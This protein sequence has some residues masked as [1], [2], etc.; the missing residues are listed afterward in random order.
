MSQE[1]ARHPFGDDTQPTITI[2]PPDQRQPAVWRQA[3]GWLSLAAALVLTVATVILVLLPPNTPDNTPV[4]MTTGDS[5]STPTQASRLSIAID[6]PATESPTPETAD[7]NVLPSATPQPRQMGR[8]VPTVSSM[9]LVGLLQTP[10]A[11]AAASDQ[12][13][14]FRQI[15]QQAQYNPFTVLPEMERSEF[16]EYTVQQG[17]TVDEIARRYGLAIDTLAWCNDS[18]IVFALFP[19]DVLRIPPQ[20]GACHLVLGTRGLTIRDIAAEY[21]VE[22]PNVIIESAFN[23]LY[24]FSPDDAPPGGLYLFIPGGIGPVVTWNPGYEAETDASGNTVFVTF[25]SG[26][27]GSCGRVEAG[28]GELWSN[29]LPNGRWVRG[30]FPGHTGID[31]SAPTGTPI[32]AAN[33]GPVLFSGTSAYG[34]GEAVVLGH[35]AWSTL[36]AHMS[37]RLA[38]CGQ[39]ISVGS[40]VGYVGSTGRSSGPHLHFE[41]RYND[42]PQD[43]TTYPVGW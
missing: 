10:I 8:V 42:E 40:V 36:Y 5:T 32:Y 34:Y 16:L 14:T 4:A 28:G 38:Q 11:P 29:P 30:F 43:P 22:N 15:F 7:T 27:S 39:Y 25:G 13:D 18:D 1:P 26:Q 17:D 12:A 35:G 6:S 24:G 23:N 37:Q 31:L 3:L 21:E 2:Q 9:Q 33:G 41:I 19:G 20:D